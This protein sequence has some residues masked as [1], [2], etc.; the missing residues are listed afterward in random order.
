[1]RTLPIACSMIL[2]LTAAGCAPTPPPSPTAVSSD[3]GSMAF[4]TPR[5]SGE[6]QRTTPTGRDTGSMSLPTTVRQGQTVPGS[7]DAGSDTGSMAY[8]APQPAGNLRR[9]T[10][11]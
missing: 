5:A 10:I 6:F 2:G 1:M 4:P 11:R 8:P 9:S 7:Q 3:T